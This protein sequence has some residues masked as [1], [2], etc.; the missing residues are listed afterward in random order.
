M[1]KT[2][3]YYD[4]HYSLPLVQ[5][6]LKILG[7]EQDSNNELSDTGNRE[8]FSQPRVGTSSETECV[9]V[10]FRLPMSVSEIA[11]DVLRVPCVAE[12]WY[13]D[14]SNNWRPIL[15]PERVPLKVRVDRSDTKSWFKWATHCYPIV[16]KKVQI[17]LTRYADGVLDTTPYPV[18]LKNTLIRRNV[19]DRHLGG[20]FEDETDVM[21]NTVSKFIRDWDASQAADDNY[22]TF[23]RSAPQPDPAAVVSLYL[24][25]RDEKGAAQVIDR[26]YLDPVYAGQ[27]LNMY[28]TSDGTVGMRELSPITLAP[29]AFTTL[30]TGTV[31]A[32]SNTTL[33]D[34]TK[35]WT[36]N[37]W[38]TKGAYLLTADGQTLQIA[39]NTATELTFASGRAPAIN[40][41]YQIGV[42]SVV[43]VEHRPGK[44][45]VDTAT[46]TADSFYRWPLTV[47]PHGNQDAWI[48]VE[49][50]PNFSTSSD[51][52]LAQNPTLFQAGEPTNTAYK[53][54]LFYDPVLRTFSLQLSSGTDSR[55]WSTSAISQ[56]WAA[57]DAIKV[58]A[59]W[60]YLPDPK[61]YLKVLDGRGR[62]I[63]SLDQQVT[64]LPQ[65]ISFDGPAQ[66]NNFRGTISNLIVKMAS[67]TTGTT[68]FLANPTLYCDPDPVI[69]GDDGKYPSTSLDNAI[70][71]APFVSR[72]HGS[73]GS[74]KSHFEDKEWTP[75]WRNYVAIKGMLHLPQPISMKYLKL[76]F[77]NLTEQPYPIYE[78]GIEVKYQ[79]YPIS[80]TQ[81]SSLG[82][83]LYTGQGGFL[84]M[85]TFISLNGV[86]SVNW[87]D[88]N[89]VMQAIGNMI[90]PQVPPVLISA[91]QP[92]L[93]D[94]LPNKGK[95]ALTDTTRI[96]AASRYVYA[97][98]A[99]Q[100]YVL[101][102]DQYNT[103][104]KAEGLQA[105][106]PYVDVPWK[107]IEEANPDSITKVNSM[108]TMPIRGTDWWI[109]PGQ[110][111][112]V[113][114]SVMRKLTDT[115]TVTERKL[116]LESRLR[117]NTTQ[118]HRYEWKTVKR[119]AA[120]A[121]F[122]GVREVQPYRSSYVAGEDTAVY[123]FPHYTEDHWVFTNIQRFKREVTDSEGTQIIYSDPVT[124]A[125]P[126]TPGVLTSK[127]LISQSDF[128]KVTL[129]FQDSGLA[130]SNSLWVDI[131]ENTDLIKDT[132]LSPY[133][134]VIPA[135]IPKGSWADAL[136]TWADAETD[137][138]TSYALVAINVDNNRRYLGKRVVHFTR[139][140]G[141]GQAGIQL[142]QWLNFVPGAKFRI[143]AVIYR[144]KKTGNNII[145][146]LKRSDGAV[147]LEEKLG[148]PRVVAT[149]HVNL[150]APG[151]SINGI[152]LSANT[153]VYLGNQDDTIDN[154][155]YRWQGASV[156]LQPVSV[157][158]PDVTEQV[159]VST[160]VN[161]VN[162]P[163]EIGG[164]AVAEN[165]LLNLTG[166]DDVVENGL[167]RFLG[168]GIPLRAE[169]NMPEI[170]RSVSSAPAGRWIDI[171]TAFAEIPEPLANA[172]F[173]LG[174]DGWI[175]HGGTWTAVSDKGYTGTASAKLATNG[176][177]S[178]L[179]GE[180]MDLLTNTTV[181]ASA[182]VNWSGLT[183][184]GN[185]SVRPVFYNLAG[186]VVDTSDLTVNASTA[187]ISAASSGS[188][189]KPVATSVTVPEGRGIVSVAFQLVVPASAGTG[190]SVWVD[191]F[192]ASVPGTPRQQ[193]TAE[194]TVEGSEEEEL[195]VS[196]LYTET[197]PIRYFAR[198]GEPPVYDQNGDL[199]SGAEPV[200]V[201]D[202][203]YTKSE[204][205]VT[206]SEPVKQMQIQAVINSP[207]AYAFGCTITPNYLR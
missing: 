105:I 11:L 206:T 66:V 127:E 135:K 74:D 57:G 142:Q 90:G 181:S 32:S 86:R 85:G 107:E 123:S 178:T 180:P 173:D 134:G 109:Y 170:F 104:I 16:A 103:I 29:S 162:P 144:P 179:T 49:W 187:A 188:T 183:A 26:V 112:K 25:V 182:W 190:G 185:I 91:G 148:T 69:V 169:T 20:S 165:T 72:E 197:T 115:Q 56:E 97:R 80:V 63:A 203:R 21:G 28:Y 71:A 84:G 76:E 64:N 172:S 195:Y 129:T 177:E 82:A 117:F 40:S 98:D 164:Q 3:F 27:H 205:I 146:R 77:T 15:D 128:S 53:P 95:T 120:I 171:A 81:S 33:T 116:T 119:D 140:A 60:K 118:V 1:A 36:T 47:G 19:Y 155:L 46:G 101:A 87:L 51:P 201:T 45:L 149:S 189:W 61:V 125:L 4:Y 88:P 42:P 93:A 161:V 34:S 12:L 18:G 154:G 65:L 24:D 92:Y 68:A 126:S 50:R 136:A 194:L 132:E 55:V 35:S 22:T 122:A 99:M 147:I 153:L 17:R 100:P 44:G 145:L 121:Y 14:R 10:T 114:A 191:D 79:T 186:D 113:P 7:K 131:D 207:N 37:Q 9:T 193:Y 139:A 175:P 204:A 106:Q 167:Y 200:E 94:T 41:K 102:Q 196:D 13:Q 163:A 156:P 168:A 96:E 108:G 111:L 38:F 5:L 6:L 52:Q 83:R 159:T 176:T 23:W 152:T 2:N 143:G 48:G 160:N 62:E 30:A 75:I 150:A 157:T 184:S 133:F 199:I 73:G 124:A 59:G 54:S 130:R 78:S 58:V 141:S 198:L 138:G 192:S 151:G 43:N 67:Y 166:Q 202:L 137:W 89:S 8:W 174:L 70:Y 158:P 110:Q 39:G 31:T